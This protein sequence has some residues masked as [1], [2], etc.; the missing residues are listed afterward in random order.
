MQFVQRWDWIPSLGVEYHVGIDGLG[1]VMVML[2]AL[3]VPFALFISPGG[4]GK[5][6]YALILCLQ[7]GLMGTFTALN[8][9]HWFV[10]WE[11][12]LIPAFFLIKNWGGRLADRAAMQ[13]FVYT[14][15]GSIA[16]LL[17]FLALYL[18]AGELQSG[19]PFGFPELAFR[20][21]PLMC[22]RRKR[23]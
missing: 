17:A 15:V 18:A 5:G 13:F 10:F 4:E 14:M 12:A 11:L 9:V 3:L 8:F 23:G 22:L 6:Y 19:H 21:P 16:L 2:S 7:T 1:L 20:S